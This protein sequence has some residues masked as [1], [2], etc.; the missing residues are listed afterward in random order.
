[1]NQ[2]KQKELL[3]A[4]VEA[5]T[6]LTILEA[7]V[8]V[9]EGGTISA[10]VQPYDFKIIDLCRKAQKKC[11]RRHDRTLIALGAPYGRADTP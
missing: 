5:H 7:V 8:A 3:R 6:D 11:L 9:L 2:K 10:D 4:L 1:M